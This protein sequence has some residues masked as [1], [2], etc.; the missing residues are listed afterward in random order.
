MKTSE[1][2]RRAKAISESKEQRGYYPCITIS[3]DDVG[4]D[5]PCL[6]T[7]IAKNKAV[8]AF[9]EAASIPFDETARIS[10]WR[11]Y[12]VFHLDRASVALFFAKA[13]EVE[14]AREAE[15]E[16]PAPAPTGAAHVTSR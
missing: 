8:L 12:D 1:V 4:M 14:E 7:G 16:V 2:L 3:I 15:A 5:E 6:A 11:W 10:V 13:I 9:I